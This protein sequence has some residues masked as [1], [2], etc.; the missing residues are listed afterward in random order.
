V[1]GLQRAVHV[2]GNNLAFAGFYPRRYPSRRHLLAEKTLGPNRGPKAYPGR[3]DQA[4]HRLG[5]STRGGAKKAQPL[6]GAKKG[7]A[8]AVPRAGFPPRSPP[9]ALGLPV[10]HPALVLHKNPNYPKPA[11]F[12]VTAHPAGC[13][14][15]R[16]D[17]MVHLVVEIGPALPKCPSGERHQPSV[18]T[19]PGGPALFA[20]HA[21][22]LLAPVR[23]GRD[24]RAKSRPG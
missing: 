22:P 2:R 10:A 18:R 19:Y 12:L 1:F 23:R 21:R 13:N 4:R 3:G 5:R 11:Q 8:S 14:P 24:S 20:W 6:A 7:P 17:G 15:T 16:R 9:A